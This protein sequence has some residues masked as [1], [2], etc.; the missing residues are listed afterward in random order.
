M[1]NLPNSPWLYMRLSSNLKDL[2]SEK[3]PS[4]SSNCQVTLRSTSEESTDPIDIC[5]NLKINIVLKWPLSIV[6]ATEE[7]EMYHS[8]FHFVIKLKWA[9]YTLNNLNLKGEQFLNTIAASF[10]TEGT[11]YL[12]LCGAQQ[13]FF[14]EVCLSVKKK[15][16][17]DFFPIISYKIFFFI[18]LHQ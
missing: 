7:I 15:V 4:I 10:V 9:L 11:F 17:S 2:I 8:I 16:F 12:K 18:F 1:E 13:K 6:V 14:H 5:D 3:Y